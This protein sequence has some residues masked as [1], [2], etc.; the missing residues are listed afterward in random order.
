MRY[1]SINLSF[2]FI[3]LILRDFSLSSRSFY[4][5]KGTLA[6]PFG[7]NPKNLRELSDE[8]KQNKLKT[9]VIEHVCKTT[10]KRLIYVFFSTIMRAKDVCKTTIEFYN[11]LV[12][13]YEEINRPSS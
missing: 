3:S 5:E 13:S 2:E 12:I 7:K 9:Q 4:L 10:M 6:L 11:S 1:L 8:N